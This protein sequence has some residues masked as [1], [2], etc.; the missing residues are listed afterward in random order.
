MRRILLAIALLSV[1]AAPVAVAATKRFAGKNEQN[2]PLSF[3]VRSGK[4]VD[5]VGVITT[6]CNGGGGPYYDEVIPPRAMKVTNGRFKYKGEHRDTLSSIE[7]AGRITGS[8]AKG[9]MSMDT[10]HLEQGEGRFYTCSADTKWSAK[11]R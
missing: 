7:I 2:R 11:L 6:F 5:F 1:V 4:V 9:R 8:T 10:H 3:K